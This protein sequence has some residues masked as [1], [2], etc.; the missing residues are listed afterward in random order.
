L[1]FDAKGALFRKEASKKSWKKIKPKWHGVVVQLSLD[2][3]TRTAEQAASTNAP[4]FQIATSIGETWTSLD[5][6][7]WTRR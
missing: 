5:G 4:P 3:G 2:P 6:R 1:G 7:H